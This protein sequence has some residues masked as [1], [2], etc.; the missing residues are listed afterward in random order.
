MRPHRRGVFANMVR[1]ARWLHAG[2]VAAV[3]AV[4]APSPALA[5]TSPAAGSTAIA[6]AQPASASSIVTLQAI[7]VTGVVPGP[8]L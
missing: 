3:V 1:R 8:G 2:L 6:S 7:N 5:Q 4:S